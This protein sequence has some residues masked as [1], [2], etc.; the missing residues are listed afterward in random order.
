MKRSYLS[1]YLTYM[2]AADFDMELT[3]VSIPNSHRPCLRFFQLHIA[4]MRHGYI[5]QPNHFPY[6]GLVHPIN[7]STRAAE[8]FQNK[9]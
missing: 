9:K 8:F 6:E 3:F 2:F 5:G 4:T 7:V 1:E